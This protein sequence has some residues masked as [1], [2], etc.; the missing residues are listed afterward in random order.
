[1]LNLITDGQ[2]R[3]FRGCFRASNKSFYD[4][5]NISG[6]LTVS[7][8]EIVRGAHFTQMFFMESITIVTCKTPPPHTRTHTHVVAMTTRLTHIYLCAKETMK[9]S[10]GT[11]YCKSEH[12]LKPCRVLTDELVNRQIYSA[13][14]HLDLFFASPAPTVTPNRRHS[15]RLIE[16]FTKWRKGVRRGRSLMKSDLIKR[17][18]CQSEQRKGKKEA[19]QR[20]GGQQEHRQ[21]IHHRMKQKD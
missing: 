10:R 6:P 16:A 1:M 19:G 5:G 20:R 13:R 4:S 3:R 8:D 15:R 9:S 17:Y 21:V 12:C 14:L 11:V 2:K 18:S 7:E